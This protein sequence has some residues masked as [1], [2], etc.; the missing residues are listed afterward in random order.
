MLDVVTEESVDDAVLVVVVGIR[1]P[2]NE[3]V[4]FRLYHSA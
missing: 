4:R 3:L 2:G 1:Y